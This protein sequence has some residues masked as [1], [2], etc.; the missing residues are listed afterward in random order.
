MAAS[1]VWASLFDRRAAHTYTHTH[2]REKKLAPK[3]GLEWAKSSAIRRSRARFAHQPG[4]SWLS[5]H[6]LY[7]RTSLP[8]YE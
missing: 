4:E 1:Q 7:A 2:G 8:A 3:L 6:L 5:L